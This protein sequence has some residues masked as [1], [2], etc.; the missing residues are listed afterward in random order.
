MN[1]ISCLDASMVHCGIAYLFCYRF[2]G[3]PNVCALQN[4]AEQVL[5]AVRRLRYPLMSGQNYR[6]SWGEQVV[7][8]PYFSSRTVPDLPQACAELY[9][10]AGTAGSWL[11]QTPIHICCLLQPD[12][13][14]FVL[15]QSGL[16]S[17]CDGN[18]ATYLF[19]QIL[20]FYQ[21]V[22]TADTAQ[23]Q[24]ILQSMQQLSSP[25][26]A[27]IYAL[28]GRFEHKVLP[29]GRWCHIVNTCRLISYPVRD[30]VRF[31]TPFDQLPQVL[32]DTLPI[33][34]APVQQQVN[35]SRLL[36]DCNTLCPEVSPHN[37]VCAL[38]A[39]AAWQLAQ[40]RGLPLPDNRI[41]FRVMIDLLNVTQRKLYIGNYIAYLP[42]T[43]DASLP[44]PA[45]AQ[46]V[47][48]R[49]MQ[50]RQA[51]QDVSMYKLLEFALR[52]GA[53]NQQNDQVSFI[54][55][56]IGN[57]RLL[58]NPGLLP[59]CQWL[60][61]QAAANSV[62][63]DQTGIRLNNRPTICFHFNLEQQLVLT[64]FNTWSDPTVSSNWLTHIRLL[65]AQGVKIDTDAVA[66]LT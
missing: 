36:D 27:Q 22:L 18:S 1:Q 3:Q 23:Q 57:Q 31:A 61:L 35:L 9:Q 7:R 63:T 55:S 15:V 25:A 46:R 19:N 41:S 47:N 51:R 64:F 65:A 40:Q 44:L 2:S 38:L 53:A 8:Q 30:H 28:C 11:Q 56:G 6:G 4:S 21:A 34:T 24:Q 29:I 45:L 5:G 12:Q 37:L 48:Q 60:E 66:D 42:V 59:D 32:P 54:V 26:P 17:Y 39:K 10:Q 49:V 14:S 33:S 13:H 52:S 58:S 43:I 20:Q 62:P 50:A 16:H